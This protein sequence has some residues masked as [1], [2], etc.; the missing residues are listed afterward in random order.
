MLKTDRDLI[1]TYN[2]SNWLVV[3]NL[4][5][6]CDFH[7]QFIYSSM[8]GSPICRIL[9]G[10]LSAESFLKPLFYKRIH[11]LVFL[12]LSRCIKRF[13]TKGCLK[14]TKLL[15]LLWCNCYTFVITNSSLPCSMYGVLLALFCPQLLK[16]LDARWMHSQTLLILLLLFSKPTS[17]QSPLLPRLLIMSILGHCCTLCNFFACPS[18]QISSAPPTDRHECIILL[19]I[20]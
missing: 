2:S 14:R 12:L 8:L 16:H 19:H 15:C 3:N 9:L 10:R 17:L 18:K 1:Y 20:H 11:I 13:F 7:C 4:P 5:L 6:G